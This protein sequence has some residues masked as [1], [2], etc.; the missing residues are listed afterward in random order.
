MSSR[1]RRPKWFRAKQQRPVDDR[2]GLCGWKPV[3]G[4]DPACASRFAGLVDADGIRES[5]LAL[6]VWADNQMPFREWGMDVSAIT[7]DF[8]RGISARAQ[9]LGLETDEAHDRR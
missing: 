7:A 9:Q 8:A 5:R 4:H 1:S 6:L 2:C 3:H